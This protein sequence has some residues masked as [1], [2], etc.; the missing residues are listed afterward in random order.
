MNP[1]LWFLILQ[2]FGAL[3]T[4][5]LKHN[6]RLKQSGSLPLSTARTAGGLE[7]PHCGPA[8]KLR[9]GQKLK[10]FAYLHTIFCTFY[11]MQDVFDEWH[12]LHTANIIRPHRSTTYVDAAYS[13]R[14]SSVV[15]L[16]VGLSVTLVSPAK[17]AAPIELP[18]GLRT[19]VGPGN[20]ILDGVQIP[21]GK[22]QI[23]GGEWASHC[24]V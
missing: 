6:G 1:C 18:F 22:G 12:V 24:K 2:E 17:T 3:Q 19:W 16:S 11:P 10:L 5:L 15:C 21:H 8:A 4:S 7:V 13:Y 14:P 20:H 23:F 9:Q